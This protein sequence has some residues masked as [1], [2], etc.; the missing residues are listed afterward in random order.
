M[1]Y[2]CYIFYLVECVIRKAIRYPKDDKQGDGVIQQSEENID[3][4]KKKW[5]SMQVLS[6]MRQT[7][8]DIAEVLQFVA[9]IDLVYMLFLYNCSFLFMNIVV[10]I[11]IHLVF[12]RMNHVK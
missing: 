10:I 2:V 4:E 6:I 3:F 5:I 9:D 1:Y 11:L 7:D 8:C 12:L